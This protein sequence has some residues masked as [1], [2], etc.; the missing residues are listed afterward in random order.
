MSAVTALASELAT[1]NANLLALAQ[2]VAAHTAAIAAN[3]SADAANA[4]SI[5]NLAAELGLDE[6]QIAK[7][8]AAA[9]PPIVIQ[10]VITDPQVQW[11][12]S[13]ET[14]DL[15]AWSEQVNTGPAAGSSAVLLAN[16][17][18]LPRISKLFG[19]P[20]LYAM[21]QSCSPTA[22]SSAGTRMARYPEIDRL[23][24]AGTPFYYSWWDFYPSAISIPASGWFNLWQIASNRSN[25]DGTL[26]PVPLW[27]LGIDNGMTLNFMSDPTATGKTYKSPLA[28][29]VGA[30]N[31]IEVYINPKADITGA[32]KVWLNGQVALDIPGVQT[33]FPLAAQ[34]IL[35]WMTSNCYAL[36]VSPVPV[37]HFVDDV[38]VSLGRMP[39]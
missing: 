12:A 8:V 27:V 35:T 4:T 18:I 11:R 33:Q 3:A 14:G 28:I 29:Q 6:A 1:T 22:S 38:T 39:A 25:A 9:S 10:P 7:L 36:G 30:W 5:Q 32:L 34:A 16:E 26:T 31:F 23:C 19:L 17:S 20:S 2:T 24:R 13:M 15:S 37:S 21:K